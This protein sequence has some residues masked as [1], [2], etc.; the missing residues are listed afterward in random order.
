MSQPARSK[1]PQRN[2]PWTNAD[3]LFLKD[4]LAHGMSYAEVAGFLGRTEEE[5]G[6]RF[7]NNRSR[8]LCA[9]APGEFAIHSHVWT[10]DSTR[11]NDDGNIFST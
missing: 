11:S 10:D 5:D 2:E 9:C 1:G 6:L 8:N 3:L 7:F 4:S